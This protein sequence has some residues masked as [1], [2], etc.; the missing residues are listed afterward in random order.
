MPTKCELERR[1]K[2]L[3]NKIKEKDR[4]LHEV[5]VKL[6]TLMGHRRTMDFNRAELLQEMH[7]INLLRLISR[8]LKKNSKLEANGN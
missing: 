6:E 1:V 2:V 5:C 4:L 8:N 7:S 3:E